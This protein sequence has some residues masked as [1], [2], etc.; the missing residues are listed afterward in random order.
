M[1]N[2]DPSGLH[3]WWQHRHIEISGLRA[4]CFHG[5]F[6]QGALVGGGIDVLLGSPVEECMGV[7]I[8][9]SLVVM[10]DDV[11]GGGILDGNEGVA[12]FVEDG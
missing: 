5:G 11:D 6:A 8:G 1:P 7:R 3:C 12:V 9:R 10:F 2:V 4:L